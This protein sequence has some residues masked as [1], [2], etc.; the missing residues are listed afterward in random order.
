MEAR[1]EGRVSSRNSSPT[2]RTLRPWMFKSGK[3]D[4]EADEYVLANRAGLALRVLA[5]SE[6]NT[7]RETQLLPP[8]PTIRVAAGTAGPSG[9]ARFR[10]RRRTVRSSRST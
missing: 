9:R 8:F 6:S 7:S 10:R 5:S 4:D 2:N 1:V 3:T